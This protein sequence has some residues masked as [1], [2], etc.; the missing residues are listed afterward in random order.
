VLL[1][2]DD[3]SMRKLVAMV[4]EVLDIELLVCANGA[5]ALDALRTAPVQ[6]LITD[7]MMPGVSGYDLLQALAETPALRGPAR[8]VVFSAGLD[9]TARAR[10]APL[11]V[12]QLLGKPV[13]VKALEDCVRSALAL[14]V[15][16]AEPGAGDC[17]AAGAA[18]P[19]EG[20][21]EQAAV[22]RYFAGQTALFEAYR[23]DCLLQFSRDL[24]DGSLALT[25]RDAPAMRRLAHNLKSV[26]RMLGRDAAAAQAQTLEDAAARADWNGMA[27]GWRGLSR[28]LTRWAKPASPPAPG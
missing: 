5:Q 20:F 2:D 8:V 25:A 21:A 1:A 7:L 15:P 19:D 24:Q 23:A 26:L 22:A 28:P 14:A 12:W 11:G 27:E 13:S 16:A 6:L 18:V 17:A 3:A 10:L 9:A 4:L